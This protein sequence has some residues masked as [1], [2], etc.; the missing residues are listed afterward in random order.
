L[1]GEV[2]LK[3]DNVIIIRV[4]K[5]E[6]ERLIK[7]SQKAEMTLSEY[8]IEQGLE[9]EILVIEDVKNFIYELRKL[10]NNINQITHLANSG[11]IKVVYLDGFKE[12]LRKIL[13]ALNSIVL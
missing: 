1:E 3:K 8:L 6:K 4:T 12:D 2:R 5:Q 11:A 7:K 10:G 13:K 9:R